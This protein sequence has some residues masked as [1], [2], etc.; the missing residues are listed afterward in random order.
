MFKMVAAGAT[1]LFVSASTLAYAQ[2]TPPRAE[3][4]SEADWNALTDFRID[5]V[6]G[7]LQL[8]P[9]QTQ[10]WPAVEEAIRARAKSR[11]ARLARV[12]ET[13]GRAGSESPMEAL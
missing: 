9:E 11:Q 1:A 8:T 4:I 13:V 6:K 5:L 2:S 12:A 3:Q 10:Y 7:A